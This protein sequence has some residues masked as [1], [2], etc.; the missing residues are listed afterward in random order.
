MTHRVLVV[1]C[2]PSKMEP[3][4]LFIEEADWEDIHLLRT[5]LEMVKL[6]VRL[7]TNSGAEGSIGY[8]GRDVYAL[9]FLPAV[10]SVKQGLRVCELTQFPKTA[11]EQVWHERTG[12]GV[13]PT[14][15]TMFPRALLEDTVLAG[16]QI[17][18]INVNP[19]DVG[20]AVL[21]DRAQ[22]LLA[23]HP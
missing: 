18:L 10:G 17:R 15:A 1:Y 13:D 9:T 23:A 11:R 16:S 12:P 20:F 3:D 4:D 22:D 6:Q 19:I 21:S 2:D 14:L 7:V 8:V 5:D